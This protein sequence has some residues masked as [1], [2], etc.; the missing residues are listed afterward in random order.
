M[1]ITQYKL[2]FKAI[3]SL[4]VFRNINYISEFI[5]YS[6]NIKQKRVLVKELIMK[7]KT[8]NIVLV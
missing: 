4:N 2:L 3:L 8:D 1:I 6:M 7:K 5:L